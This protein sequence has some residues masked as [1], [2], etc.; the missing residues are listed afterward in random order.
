MQGRKVVDSHT[1]KLQKLFVNLKNVKANRNEIDFF[2]QPMNFEEAGL[3]SA[4]KLLHI[5]TWWNVRVVNS[6]FTGK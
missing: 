6:G 5:Q 4:A 3:V 2:L 1:S